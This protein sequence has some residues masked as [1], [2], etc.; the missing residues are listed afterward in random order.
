[1]PLFCEN[2]LPHVRRF[3]RKLHVRDHVRSTNPFV[4]SEVR[5]LLVLMILLI[6]DSAAFTGWTSHGCTRVEIACSEP[7]T[8]FKIKHVTGTDVARTNPNNPNMRMQD[9]STA[10]LIEGVKQDK[11]TP[12]LSGVGRRQRRRNLSTHVCT[13]LCK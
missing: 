8:M 13:Q 1:M 7:R 11:Q 2:Q 6:K 4:T 10:N 5:Y 9:H 12:M 3:K